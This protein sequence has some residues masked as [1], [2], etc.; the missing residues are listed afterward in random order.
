MV[1]ALGNEF[2]FMVLTTDRDLNSPSRYEGVSVDQ[3]GRVGSAYVNYLSKDRWSILKL[4]RA[5]RA[6]NASLMYLNSF[7]GFLFSIVPLLAMR[8]G[9]LK[10][11]PVVLAPR[12]EFSGG[13]LAQ[14][15][16]KK[17]FFIAVSRMLALHRDVF[18]HAST[19][20]EAEDIRRSM[21]REVSS[22][23]IARNLSQRVLPRDIVA[24]SQKFV[25]N[26][27]VKICF[28]SRIVEKKNLAFALNVLSNVKVP[29]EFGVYGPIESVDYWKNCELL[30]SQLP[31]NIVVKYLGAVPNHLVAQELSSY[32]LFFLPTLGENFG[33]VFVEALAAGLPILVSDQTPWRD[34]KTHGV[35]WDIPLDRPEDFCAAIEEYFLLDSEEKRCYAD[36]CFNFALKKTQLDE[37]L[38]ANRMLFEN[39]LKIS[40]E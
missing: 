32:Q 27:S 2:D 15:S 11:I 16:A 39:A 6:S 33:H 21:G 7:F 4:L 8:V 40:T 36:R 1:D 14:K 24:Q 22:I 19:D 37:L 38:G 13:A 30:I 34:L 5:A 9:F 25:S 18:W 23:V 28:L 20:E 26:A 31:K 10:K 17:K 3:W 12:G 35:G 29:V